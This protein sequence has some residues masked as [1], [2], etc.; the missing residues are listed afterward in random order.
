MKMGHGCD[1]IERYLLRDDVIF[2][3]DH[4]SRWSATIRLCE[5]ESLVSDM[6]KNSLYIIII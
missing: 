4:V 5:P 3:S 2:S 1:I 6:I